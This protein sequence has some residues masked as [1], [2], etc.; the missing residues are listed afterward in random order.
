V[1]KNRQDEQDFP[2]EQDED[3]A[4]NLLFKAKSARGAMPAR[5]NIVCTT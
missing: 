4:M 5:L 1:K 2:D 3:L